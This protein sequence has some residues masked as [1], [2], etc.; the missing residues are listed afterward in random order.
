MSSVKN[1]ASPFDKYDQMTDSN[2]VS[3][4]FPSSCK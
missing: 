3:Q 4:C 2:K 1:G